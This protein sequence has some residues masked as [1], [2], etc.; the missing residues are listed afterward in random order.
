MI[1][2]AAR[3]GIALGINLQ[4]NVALGTN[5]GEARNQLW[6][7][8]FRLEHFLSDMTGRVSC[9]GHDSSSAPP[10][11]P[12]SDP[13]PTASDAPRL[14]NES[15]HVTGL[16]W[17]MQLDR[18]QMGFQRTLLDSIPASPSLYF[19]H[20]VDLSLVAHDISNPVYAI[21]VIKTGWARVESRIALYSKKVDYWVSNLHPSFCFQ[22]K[23]GNQLPGRKSSFQLS[24]ALIT[25]ALD[26]C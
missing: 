21:G 3:S 20:M 18:K 14:K 9:I 4:R 8:I 5:T 12:L 13:A 11:L 16:Q 19:F 2:I 26:L 22:D 1:G 17:T 25:T 7:S 6:W 15:A 23:Y 10:P 24:L